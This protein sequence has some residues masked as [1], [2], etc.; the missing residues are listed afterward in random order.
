MKLLAIET[1]TDIC[2]VAL[3]ENNQLVAEYLLNQKNVHNEKLISTVDYLIKEAQWS[4]KE[5]DGIVLVIGPGSFS[6]LRIGIAVSKGLAYSLD[7]PLVSVNTLDAMANGAL[8]WTG[9]ICT[10]LK[11][12]AEEVYF[13]L[14]HKKMDGLQRCSEYQIINSDAV[15]NYITEKT[16]VISHPVDM[17]AKITADEAI[18]APLEHTALSPFSVAKMG[19]LKIQQKETEDLASLEPLYLQEFTPKRKV[20]YN[21]NR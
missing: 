3:T 4:L 8:F 16:L 14:Y 1:A 20:Y 13:A 21:E 6:G 17:A 18:L 5:L 12:R 7:I 10:I 19:Y 11:A 15:D 2:G 9:K